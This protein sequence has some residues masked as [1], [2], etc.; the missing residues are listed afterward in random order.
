MPLDT[1]MNLKFCLGSNEDLENYKCGGFHP[2]DLA[3]KFKNGRYVV[4]H[5]LGYGGFSTVWLARD[6]EQQRY[7][8]LKMITA[9]STKGLRELAVQR[10]L[11][12]S[13]ATNIGVSKI[14]DRF[15]FRGPNGRHIC[16]IFDVHGPSLSILSDHLYKLRPDIGRALSHQVATSLAQIHGQDIAFGDLSIHNVL[17]G[18]ED[19][20]DWTLEQIYAGL[21]EP[22][23]EEVTAHDSESAA[24]IFEHAPQVTYSPIEWH[25]T[26]LS[27]FTPIA[28]LTDLN[29]AVYVGRSAELKDDGTEY[30]A[31]NYD[32]MAPEYAFGIQ[33]QHSK[34]SDVWALGCIFYELRTSES[35]FGNSTKSIHTAMQELL[36]ELPGEWKSSVS[37]LPSFREVV[38]HS[39]DQ[40]QLHTIDEKLDK[41]GNWLPWL[42]MSAKDRKQLIIDTQGGEI[43]QQEDNPMVKDIDCKPSPPPARLSTEES[44]DLKDLLSKMLVWRPEDRIS[45]KEVLQHP[46]LNKTY[47]GFDAEDAWITQFHWGW[48][49]KPPTIVNSADFDMDDIDVGGFD[50]DDDDDYESEDEIEEAVDS[51][52]V[53]EDES[54]TS[55]DG[56]ANTKNPRHVEA[57]AADLRSTSRRGSQNVVHAILDYARAPIQL[58]Q[59][60]WQTIA[61]LGMA[62]VATVWPIKNLEPIAQH[63]ANETT[64][65]GADDTETSASIDVATLEE[66]KSGQS[67]NFFVTRLLGLPVVVGKVGSE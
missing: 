36:G 62:I 6:T 31:V 26:D 44:A 63:C 38:V 50:L 23:P 59:G 10:Y 58:M 9:Q 5:K 49:P 12:R 24:S 61:Q 42:S 67:D 51:N 48:D 52:I 64:L 11:F 41:V 18:F 37:S 20:T 27:L 32:Y 8:A 57:Q 2:I 45:M 15:A 14:L 13:P 4:V 60:A 21:G 66:V 56:S 55:E 1:N 25:S 35:L 19:V 22:V 30:G 17:L 53:D 16:L 28:L 65:G 3:D 29:E 54:Q 7:V 47:T 34:A 39:R 46:W 33:S 43:L 40:I